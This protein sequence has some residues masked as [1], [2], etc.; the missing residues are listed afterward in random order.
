MGR[1][2]KRVAMDFRWPLNKTWGGFLN[3]YYRHCAQCSAC[4]GSGHNPATKQISDDFYDFAETGRRWCDAL[5]QDEVD[6]LVAESRLRHWNGETRAWESVPRTAAE[7]NAANGRG[8]SMLGDMHHDGIN[9]WI[10][11]KARA[12]RLG[13]YGDCEVCKGDGEIWASP[14]KKKL[15]EEWKEEE[16][17]TGDGWQMWETTSE[18]SP[19]SP[20]F[21]SPEEL[22]R[23]L[24]DTGASSFGG[25]TATYEQWLG[26]CRAGW[27][28]SAI[29]A[30]GLGF[31]SGVEA[32]AEKAGKL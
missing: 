18:G 10:V 8:S 23:W 31:V 24:A 29:A 1:E 5:T 11:I 3:P 16:P 13:V 30:P 12:K 9:R 22:S 4:D 19:I 7:V 32:V 17:P 27:A 25:M 20:V 2:V 15:A 6:T 14:E 21:A 26:M 28:P